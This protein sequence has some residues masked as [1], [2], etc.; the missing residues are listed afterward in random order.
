MAAESRGHSSP[1]LDP[2]VLSWTA[3]P[4]V[5]KVLAE[6]RRRAERGHLGATGSLTLDLDDS[7]RR[8]VGALLGMEWEVSGRRVPLALLRSALARRGVSLEEVL[9]AVGG[10][11]H[12]RVSARAEARQARAAE[13]DNARDT[14]SSALVRRAARAPVSDLSI[15]VDSLVA[16]I[17]SSSLPPAGTGE[18]ALRASQLACVIDLLG[19]HEGAFLSVLAADAFG[20]AHALDQSRALGRAAARAVGHLGAEPVL[21]VRSSEDWRAAWEGVG[22]AC[23]RV[24]STVLVLNLPLGGAPGL[25][26]LADLAG[27]PVWLT[28]RMLAGDIEVPDGITRVFVCENPS[29]IETVA[30]RL[31]ADSH[32]LVC[33]Y[34][35][36]SLA[37]LS[38]LRA[39]HS[40]GVEVLLSADHDRGG[41]LVKEAVRSACP[42]A[43]DW[44]AT[45][46]GVYAEERLPAML[47]DL[48]RGSVRHTFFATS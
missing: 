8:G 12:D 21:D 46:P 28:A 7:E 2:I 20:D 38:L 17:T 24:S 23:D 41:Q 1:G 18:R 31:G 14:F 29:V 40:A 34:G 47:R 32:P 33:T 48:A 11:I 15:D 45:E 25:P 30:D 19:A 39:L 36:P 37:A 10:P 6:A 4:G 22:V 42:D 9:V 44:L 27:E 13:E 5:A 26:A 43:Q 3:R 35:R 16:A